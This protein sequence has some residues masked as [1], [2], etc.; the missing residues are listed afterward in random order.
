MYALTVIGLVPVFDKMR[1]DTATVPEAM[2]DI[3]VELDV[4]TFFTAYELF[5]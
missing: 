2:L 5:E 1:L 4:L 3:T